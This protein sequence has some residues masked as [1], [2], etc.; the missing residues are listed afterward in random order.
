MVEPLHGMYLNLINPAVKNSIP[1]VEPLHG[2]YLNK[3]GPGTK[4][5]DSLKLNLYMGCI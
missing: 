4:G 5:W 2:M 3:I 1:S